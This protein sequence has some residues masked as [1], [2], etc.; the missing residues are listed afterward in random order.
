MIQLFHTLKIFN[1]F[2]QIAQTDR[3][4]LGSWPIP[5]SVLIALKS[6]IW[7]FQ[8]MVATPTNYSPPTPAP[9]AEA[10]EVGRRGEWKKTGFPNYDW[11]A[12][13]S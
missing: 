10:R 9:P 13:G 2:M 4:V 3:R 6:S 8:S 7:R 5:P 1:W 11:F 12:I